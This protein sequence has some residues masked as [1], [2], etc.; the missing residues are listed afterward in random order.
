MW[1]SRDG[2]GELKVREDAIEGLEL[3]WRSPKVQ[4]L[5][6]TFPNWPAGPYFIFLK[7]PETAWTKKKHIV[8]ALGMLE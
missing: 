4:G 1:N 2:G 3:E 6:T 7:V 8:S 5:D